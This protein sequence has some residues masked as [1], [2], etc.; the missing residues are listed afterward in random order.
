MAQLDGIAVGV[1][2][3][4]QPAGGVVDVPDGL[5]AARIENARDVVV[6]W[7]VLYIVVQVT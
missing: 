7:V 6:A 4:G 5:D 3:F 2:G 1:L